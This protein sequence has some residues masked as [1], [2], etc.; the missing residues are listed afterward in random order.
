MLINCKGE[1]EG[2]QITPRKLLGVFSTLLMLWE[3][4]P[5]LNGLSAE[6]STN[7]EDL[8]LRMKRE[9]ERH[10]DQ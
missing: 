1:G 4:S 2:D 6:L 9:S 7:Y 8:G 3:K 10:L 5:C